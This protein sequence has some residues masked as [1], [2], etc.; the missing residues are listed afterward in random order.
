MQYDVTSP[1]QYLDSL[2]EDWRK[3]VLSVLR[4]KILESAPT[5]K[6]SIEYKML[7][8]GDDT[9][10]IFHLNAQKN[11]VSLYVGDKGKIDDSGELL[12]GLD[13][14]KG[15]IRIKKSTRLEETRIIDFIEKALGI[16]KVGGDTSC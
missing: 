10:S 3:E 2:S 13:V 5:I 12:Q 7:R 1:Q 4:N 16:F 6:E 8:Y 9:T 11:Y 14:G 15:C